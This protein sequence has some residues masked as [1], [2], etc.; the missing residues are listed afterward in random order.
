MTAA[1][2][3]TAGSFRTNACAA[4]IS[5]CRTNAIAGL[6]STWATRHAVSAKGI[7]AGTPTTPAARTCQ[8]SELHARVVLLVPTL[9]VRKTHARNTARE[10][11]STR[12]RPCKIEGVHHRCAAP[13]PGEPGP[14]IGRSAA[15]RLFHPKKSFGSVAEIFV[16][17][18]LAIPIQNFFQPLRWSIRA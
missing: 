10:R 4:G 12:R 14:K 1:A 17:P 9:E 13:L 5:A 16:T 11:T 15:R 8:R 18:P 7:Y 2:S 3:Q 6:G